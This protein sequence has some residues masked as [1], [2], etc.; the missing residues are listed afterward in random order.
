MR[1]TL[2]NYFTTQKYVKEFLNK[3]LR[4]QDIFLS[5]LKYKFI[6]DFEYF[7]R[8]HKPVDH[9][10]PTYGHNTVM[11]HNERLRKMINGCCSDGMA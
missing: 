2:K 5:Q 9:H 10:K 6:V 8:Q 3:Q 11:K 7:L 4:I 1:H